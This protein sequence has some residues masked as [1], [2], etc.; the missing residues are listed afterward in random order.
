MRDLSKAA[1]IMN[2]ASE[3]AKRCYR[4][5]ELGREMQVLI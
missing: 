1:T 4:D 2:T 5:A 3:Q